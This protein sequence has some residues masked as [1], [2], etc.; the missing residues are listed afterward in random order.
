MCKHQGSLCTRHGFVSA[1]ARHWSKF[2]SKKRI[3]SRVIPGYYDFDY[4]ENM[5]IVMR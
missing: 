2:I 1:Q 5:V 4:I 3:L